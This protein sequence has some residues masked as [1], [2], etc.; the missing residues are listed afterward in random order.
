MSK[1][2]G[3]EMRMLRLMCGTTMSDRIRNETICETVGV[4]P[5]QDKLR[6]NRL[7]WFEHIYRRPTD[8]V[9]KK[10]DIV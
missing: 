5:I 2:S 9:V 7:R 3:A 8:A 6:D 10:S 1:M 4:V